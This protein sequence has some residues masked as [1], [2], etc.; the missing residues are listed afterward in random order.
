MPW[1]LGKEH[2]KRGLGMDVVI[3]ALLGYILGFFPK[4]RHEE[5]S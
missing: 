2:I 1:R 5:D 4:F 3:L